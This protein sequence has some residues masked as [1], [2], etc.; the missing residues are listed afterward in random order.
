MQVLII[1]GPWLGVSVA[2]IVEEMAGRLQPQGRGQISRQMSAPPGGWSSAIPTQIGHAAPS[3]HDEA[4]QERL[5]CIH[6]ILQTAKRW[7]F[8]GLYRRC[9][10]G[11]SKEV[12]QQQRTSNCRQ[13]AFVNESTRRKGCQVKGGVQRPR[14]RTGTL[15]VDFIIAINPVTIVHSKTGG[16]SREVGQNC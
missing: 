2:W 10:A 9:R 6:R 13:T 4:V 14:H 8:S 11:R 12:E 5:I 1:A 3:L 15:L 16:A 7:W